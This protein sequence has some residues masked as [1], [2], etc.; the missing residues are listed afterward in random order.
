MLTFRSKIKTPPAKFCNV[1]HKA[2]PMATPAEANKAINELVSI[3]MIEI[4]III[5]I[6][7]SAILTTLK[8]NEDNERST[9]LFCNNRLTLLYILLII[10]FPT[11]N[12]RIATNSLKAKSTAL[13]TS[14]SIT[15][16]IGSFSQALVV[17]SMLESVIMLNFATKLRKIS[18]LWISIFGKTNKFVLN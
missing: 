7:R 13:V 10:I 15:S 6:K 4:E 14:L 2:I 11:Q 5:R 16:S 9:C 3:P 18:L 12:M 1:P 8:T 17:R